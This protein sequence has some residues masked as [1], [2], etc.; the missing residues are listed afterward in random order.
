MMGSDIFED[1]EDFAMN[2]KTGVPDIGIGENTVIRDAII[3]KNARI[4]ANVILDPAGKS[5]DFELK[6]VYVRD[7]VLVVSKNAVIPD[8]TVI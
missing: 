3:D 8:N 6:G 4:G 2:R 1:E 5:D 7:G